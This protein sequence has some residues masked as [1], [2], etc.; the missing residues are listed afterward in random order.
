[1]VGHVPVPPESCLSDDPLA[2]PC[3]RAAEFSLKYHLHDQAAFFAERILAEKPDSDHAMELLA[4]ALLR[5]GEAARVRWLLKERDQL[6]PRLR[7]LLAVACLRLDHYA[8]AEA[9]LF[10]GNLGLVAAAASGNAEALFSVAEG[11]PGLFLLGRAAEG[12]QKRTQALECYAKCLELSPFMWCAYERLS[13][14]S[15][16]SNSAPIC[17]PKAFAGTVF[18]AT[19]LWQDS[20]LH[21]CSI[22]TELPRPVD[23]VTM[24][25]PARKVKS[26][27]CARASSPCTPTRKRRRSNGNGY[28][29][30]WG[31]KGDRTPP[32]STPPMASPFSRAPFADRH[33]ISSPLQQASP[34]RV[35]PEAAAPAAVTIPVGQTSARTLWSRLSPRRLLSSPLGSPFRSPFA[36]TGGLSASLGSSQPSRGTSY[37]VSVGGAP[38]TRAKEEAT[39]FASLLQKLGEALHAVHRFSCVE[40]L[41]I[42]RSLPAREQTSALVQNL[43][44]RCHFEL[45]EYADAARVYAQCC[46][47]HKLYRPLGLEYYSVAL[48]HLRE[49]LELGDLARRALEWDRQRP[50]VWCVVGNCFSIQQ[51][52]EQAIRCFRRAIQLD[53]SFAY[54]HTLIGHELMASEKYDKA[55]QMYEQAVAIDCRHYNAWWGLGS[56]YQRQEEFA[57]AKYHF[58]KAVDINGCNAVLRTSLG[59]V[60][61][62]LGEPQRALG[63]FSRAAQSRHCGALASFQKGCVLSTLGRHAEAV[64]ELKR[65]RGLAPREACVHFQLGRAHVGSGDARLALVHFTTAMDL[66]GAKDSKDHQLIVSAQDEL[67]RALGGQGNEA[68]DLNVGNQIVTP[69]SRA[70]RRRRS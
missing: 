56:V 39:P 15:L 46:E 28:G 6:T 61:Q 64:D 10:A 34:T 38:V 2:G 30:A 41:E 37:Q 7:Y 69:G 9:A 35:P 18:E 1:M 5:A 14:L 32:V 31:S 16:S 67:L 21:P 27:N 29:F 70:Q 62:A 48:W 47:A 20:V 65:A 12:M 13:W 17:S 19:K 66:C 50:Q 43:V 45:A 22:S 54:A 24:G 8:E 11:A 63:F 26:R 53:P 60:L 25:S 40:A 23:G 68:D 36:A 52:H 51:E 4:D 59:I 44:A 49:T 42:L 3:V 33:P 57:K 58:Q 55:V